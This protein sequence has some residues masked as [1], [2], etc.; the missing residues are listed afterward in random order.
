[1]FKKRY[2]S[3]PFDAKRASTAPIIAYVDRWW[4]KINK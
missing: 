3:D 2:G 4:E 1:M